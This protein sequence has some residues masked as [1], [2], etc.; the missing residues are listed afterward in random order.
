MWINHKKLNRISGSISGCLYN[1]KEYKV[2]HYVRYNPNVRG[3]DS[4]ECCANNEGVCNIINRLEVSYGVVEIVHKTD[5]EDCIMVND[6]VVRTGRFLSL[7]E[8]DGYVCAIEN[9][10]N[11]NM[12]ICSFRLLKVV[13]TQTIE[14]AGDSKD[15]CF[16]K[17]ATENGDSANRQVS[18]KVDT[19]CIDKDITGSDAVFLLCSGVKCRED[20]EIKC[21]IIYNPSNKEHPVIKVDIPA[22]KLEYSDVNSMWTDGIML[23]VGCDKQ[24]VM[25]Y[26][27]AMDVEYWTSLDEDVV[28]SL[29]VK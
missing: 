29:L 5:A 11:M 22:E 27:P 18:I 16:S 17:T 13:N 7:F 28:K 24:V 20:K 25:L 19:F 26:L 4:L 21:L 14:T 1:G 6:K 12:G 10:T 15:L 8:Y 9:C 2:P 23:T 3:E